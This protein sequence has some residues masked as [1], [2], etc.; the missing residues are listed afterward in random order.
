M[1]FA[2]LA[3]SASLAV[4]GALA[5]PVAR[6]TDIPQLN[7]ISFAP[8]PVK[9]APGEQCSDTVY[10]DVR[11]PRDLNERLNLD[12]LRF[13]CARGEV[14]ARCEKN[15]N[16]IYKKRVD[17]NEFFESFPP[18]TTGVPSQQEKP[19]FDPSYL[20]CARGEVSA[21]CEKNANGIY[22]KRVDPNEFFESFP[23]TTTGAPTQQQKPAFDP[24]HLA[25]ARGEVQ[26]GARCEAD[27]F[28]GI[29]KK[30][31]P[32]TAAD[33]LL[34]SFPPAQPASQQQEKTS[35]DPSHL[36]CARGEVQVGARCE[37][38]PFT[39]IVKRHLIE[40]VARSLAQDVVKRFN[41]SNFH[42]PV[43]ECAR[44]EVS[45]RCEAI[46]GIYKKRLSGLEPI[47]PLVPERPV[48]D[49]DQ[50]EK[51][52]ESRFIATC[53][54]DDAGAECTGTVQP[55]VPTAFQNAFEKIYG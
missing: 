30:R 37:A 44:G 20:A 17:P 51:R 4:S 7:H 39:G 23:P 21:R 48:E 53:G 31:S 5:A 26:V 24:S 28:T 41:L 52:F 19:A 2:L 49:A 34:T 29:V 14:S 9:C 8:V 18:T 3:V 55:D 47:P 40:R 6:S 42:L 13:A 16:G 33:R 11:F 35:F 12:D 46:N 38:N 27:P 50:N 43:Y 22:K 1:H 54:R 10:G 15:A 36:A 45:A 25:C 32:Q